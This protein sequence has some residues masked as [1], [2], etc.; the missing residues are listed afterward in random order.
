MATS[1]LLTSTVADVTSTTEQLP[2]F[3]VFCTAVDCA[4][5]TVSRIAEGQ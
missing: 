1:D 2:D 3:D 4:K 5:D